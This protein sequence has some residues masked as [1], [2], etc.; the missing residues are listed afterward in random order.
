MSKVAIGLFM[1][2]S[3][4][5][6]P[7]PCT[8][9]Q[10]EAGYICRGTDIFPR[11]QRTQSEIAGAVATAEQREIE[12]IPLMA[13]YAVSGGLIVRQVFEVLL[14]EMLEH[15]RRELPVDGVFLAL[16]GGM[17]AEQADDATGHILEAVRAMVG[18]NIP[19]AASLDLHANVTRKMGRAADILV[20]YHTFPHVDM[21]E[22]GA[23]AMELLADCIGGK[24]RPVMALQRLPMILT[25][26][27]SATTH[28]PY[29]EIMQ[30]VVEVEKKPGV[31]SGSAF[32]VQPWLDLPDVGCS[33]IVITDGDL[34]LA[35]QEADRLADSFW[36]KRRAFDAQLIPLDEAIHRAVAAK[37][38]PVIFSDGADAPSSGAPGDSTAIL[39]ALLEAKV[40]VETLINIVDSQAVHA[41]I[42]AGVGSEIT[43][44]VG[45]KSTT[46]FWS[47]VEITGRVRLISDGAFRFKG[48][49]FRGVEFQRGRTVVL[50]V[51]SIYLEIM[52]HPVFQWDPEL[53]R[54]VGLEPCDARIVVVKSPTGFRA[55]YEPIAAQILLVDA[56]G[57]CSSNLHSFPWKHLRRP[58]YPMDEI[59]DWRPIS[60]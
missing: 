35:E 49:G 59:E 26:E 40:E 51:G 20:G 22:C 23:R 46:L 21:Y 60:A 24:I 50:Q 47:P 58:C 42:Q 28:G 4:S 54:S 29:A 53:Y 8:W 38:G 14:H 16:H 32:S 9:A 41:A 43:L 15:L 56:P 5:F 2:E 44:T 10:F 7:I 39:K 45:A 12:I 18:A 17:V 33:V 6:T 57:V 31:L 34:P 11:F 27:N 1:Q 52:E 13:C 55:A 37:C 48:P 3:H 19:I 30:Q 25:A 36:A